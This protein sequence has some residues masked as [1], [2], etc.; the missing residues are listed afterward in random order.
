MSGLTRFAKPQPRNVGLRLLLVI[1][2]KQRNQTDGHIVRNQ[3]VKLYILKWRGCGARQMSL[4]KS[5]RLTNKWRNGTV[6]I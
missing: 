3:G 6:I 4:L 5:I 1:A 2:A